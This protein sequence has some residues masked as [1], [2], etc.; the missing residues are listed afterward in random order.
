MRMRSLSYKIQQIITN[1]CT[2]FQNP[3]CSSSCKIFEKHIEENETWT[4]KGNDKHEDADS[5]LDDTSSWTQC[6]YRISKS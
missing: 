1:V 6:L 4:N 5:A 3:R 2:E